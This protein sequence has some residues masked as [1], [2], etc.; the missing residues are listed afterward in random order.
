MLCFLRWTIWR[1]V[2][3]LLLRTASKINFAF[4]LTIG[5]VLLS[6]WHLRILFSLCSWLFW[7]LFCL[8][9]FMVF[10]FI[11]LVNVIETVISIIIWI[12]IMSLNWSWRTYFLYR[13]LLWGLQSI[14][15]FL[16]NLWILTCSNIISTSYWWRTNWV[17]F[18]LWFS[19]LIM[20]KSLSRLV[21]F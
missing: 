1:R 19:F 12:I 7:W 20:H 18:N 6:W 4:K 9:R 11:K 13:S 21:V 15:C 5:I 2:F 3:K 17:T 16:T 8:R 14:L 10:F